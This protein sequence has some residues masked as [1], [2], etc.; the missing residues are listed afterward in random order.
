M[1]SIDWLRSID[2]VSL[3]GFVPLTSVPLSSVLLTGCVPLSSIAL[4]GFVA[5]VV[6]T[7][8]SFSMI[9][10]FKCCDFLLSFHDLVSFRRSRCVTLNDCVPLTGC[11]PL[12]HCPLHIHRLILHLIHRLAEPPP[13]PPSDPAKTDP[14]PSPKAEPPRAI[15]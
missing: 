7:Y 8:I 4:N 9:V 13:E 3:N 1:R 11:V 2:S 6:L 10:L 5:N 15:A 12:G 14:D